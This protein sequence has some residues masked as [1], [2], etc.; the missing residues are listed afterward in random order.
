MGRLF[1]F[2]LVGGMNTGVDLLMFTVFI[3]FG[4]PYLIAQLFSYGCGV[5][6]SYLFNRHWTFNQKKSAS[7]NEFSKFLVVNLLTLGIVTGMLTFLHQA[8]TL[9]ILES[10]CLATV[11]GLGFNFIGSKWWVF[12]DDC[13]PSRAHQA[14]G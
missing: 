11:V 10:K 14:K 5:L 1:K 9:P 3:H 12:R 8:L 7:R 6:N 4:I 2:A 13:R